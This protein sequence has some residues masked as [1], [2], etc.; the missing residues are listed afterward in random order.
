VVAHQ[1]L[2]Q[3]FADASQAPAMPPAPPVTLAIPEQG[4]KKRKGLQQLAQT[5][6]PDTMARRLEESQ[7]ANSPLVHHGTSAG[8]RHGP[9][10]DEAHEHYYH[11]PAQVADKKT[12]SWD[13][14]KATSTSMRHDLDIAILPPTVITGIPLI[15]LGNSEKEVAKAVSCFKQMGKE[16]IHGWSVLSVCKPDCHDCAI[17]IFM[18]H[19]MVDAIRIFDSSFLRPDLG[20]NLGDGIAAVKEKFGEPSFIL[21]DPS[22]VPTQNYIYPISQIGFQ[23]SRSKEDE[24]PKIVS[25]IVFNVK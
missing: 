10:S 13:A 4:E 9:Y 25:M 12:I 2:Q 15:R 24:P 17:Q 11:M 6:S 22:A 18:R 21:S 5:L 23:L 14:W 8:Y 19:G 1:P 3:Q 7:L 16:S 20:V